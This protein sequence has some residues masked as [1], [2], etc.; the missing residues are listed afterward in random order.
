M[1]SQSDGA[2]NVYFFL[3][4]GH[5]STRM[6][7]DAA[8][9]IVER[10]AYDAFGQTLVGIDLTSADAAKTTWLFAGDGQFD[11]ANG[12]TNHIARWR[13]GHLFIGRDPFA[14]DHFDP[15]SLHKYLYA[16]A[17]PVMYV[18]PS[19]LFGLAG[20]AAGFGIAN[21]IRSIPTEVVLS[22]FD[23]AI[24]AIDGVQ[25]GQNAQQIISS[26]VS[27]Q[28]LGFGLGFAGGKIFQGAARIWEQG[29][30]V[31]LTQIG[32]RAG[33]S[34]R[35]LAIVNNGAFQLSRTAND[36]AV[37]GHSAPALIRPNAARVRSAFNSNVL[38]NG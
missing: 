35:A 18:D 27:N 38:K 28:V 34:G 16:H 32:R 21:S 23:A 36:I 20:F 26:F 25:A 8:A 19:G 5:G 24:T 9:A 31:A 13:Q 17:N 37:T 10:Y 2:G 6:L 12:L 29:I 11:P 3:H 14:G 22:A 1:I 7:V 15:I 30:T 33:T 4:D